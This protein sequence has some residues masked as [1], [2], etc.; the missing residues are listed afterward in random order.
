MF[1]NQVR[2]SRESEKWVAT[3]AKVIWSQVKTHRGSDSTSDSADI[4]YRDEFE[5]KIFRSN[6]DSFDNSSGGRESAQETVRNYPKGKTVV[7]YV[8]PEKPWQSVLIQEVRN[9]VFWLIFSLVFM[10]FAGIGF[11]STI[12]G[13]RKNKRNSVSKASSDPAPMFGG[14]HPS[15]Q[16]Y[17]NTGA[18]TQ[19]LGIASDDGELVLTPENKRLQAFVL[20]V[21]VAVIWNGIMFMVS[22]GGGEN[23][24]WTW[25]FWRELFM[26]NKIFILFFAIGLLFLW[27]II[28][29]FLAIFNPKPIVTLS[30]PEI[31]IGEPIE[32]SWKVASG[33]SRF[34]KFTVELIGGEITRYRSGKNTNT[35]YSVFYSE[36]SVNIEQTQMMGRG[37]QMIDLPPESGQF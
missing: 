32:L 29:N 21:F 4:F 26:Q 27:S 22:T 7:C 30:K 33:A 10:G 13:S 16:D 36:E 24:E 19:K 17:T 5:G 20:M 15:S 11:I 14:G 25:E 34:R 6:R 12:R 31:R 28:Y 9:K 8:N 23:V 2:Q 18:S 3:P 35:A 37:S 1:L